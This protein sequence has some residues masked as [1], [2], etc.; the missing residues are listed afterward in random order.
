MAVEEIGFIEEVL[1]PWDVRYP[2]PD[3]MIVLEYTERLELHPDGTF[4]WTPAPSWAAS[5]GAW[6]MVRHSNGSMELCFEEANGGMRCQFLV[7]MRIHPQEPIFMNWQRTDGGA[8]VF[9]DRIFRADRPEG[10]RS[11]EES[12]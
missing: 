5:I 3:D 4:S 8:V 2:G 1:G 9:R 11:I 12:N 6:H 10:Y 7:L